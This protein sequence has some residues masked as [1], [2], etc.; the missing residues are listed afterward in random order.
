[1][2]RRRACVPHV[3]MLSAGGSGLPRA[4][5]DDDAPEWMEGEA[6]GVSRRVCAVGGSGVAIGLMSGFTSAAVTWALHTSGA[7]GSL[8]HGLS[9]SLFLVSSIRRYCLGGVVIGG[10]EA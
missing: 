3:I 5:E 6:G 8:L 1:M 4:D 7:R 2:G 9:S 10:A